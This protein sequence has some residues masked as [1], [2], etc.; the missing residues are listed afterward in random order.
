[1]NPVEASPIVEVRS[2]S[3]LRG[4]ERVLDGLDLCVARGEIRAIM[5]PNGVG[6]STLVGCLL[7]Q[8]DFTGEILLHWEGSGRIGYVPQEAP[9][10]PSLPLTA[11][12]FLALSRT[13]RPVALGLGRS[14]RHRVEELLAQVGLEGRADAPVA[15]LSGGERRRLLLAHAL[16]PTPELLLLDEPG[17]GLDPEGMDRLDQIVGEARDRWGTTVIIVSHQQDRVERLADRV[18]H[19]EFARGRGATVAAA[20]SR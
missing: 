8:V 20:G 4:A 18:T 16:D 5:G 15:G 7:G 11:E 13:R 1:M 2:L 14:T 10:E 12:T 19:L 3:V 9:V 6:K 17:S